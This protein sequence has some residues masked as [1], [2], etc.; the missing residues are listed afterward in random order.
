[1]SKFRSVSSELTTSLADVYLAPTQF[2]STVSSILVT[3]K[4]SSAA[5][6]TMNWEKASD[7]STNPI[8]VATSIPANGILQITDLL[9]LD[10]GDSIEASASANSALQVTVRAEESFGQN[11]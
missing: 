3:N 6:V 1:M 7:S 4:T 10:K 2:N 8:L 11:S 5:T 9:Y